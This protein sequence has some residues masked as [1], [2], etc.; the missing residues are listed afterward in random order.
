MIRLEGKS[1]LAT[2]AARG[3]GRCLV[4]VCSCEERLAA[5]ATPEY[6]NHLFAQTCNVDGGP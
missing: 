4:E 2:G 5:D 3:I 6:L 1:A